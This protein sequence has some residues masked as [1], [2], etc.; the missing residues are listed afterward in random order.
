MQSTTL[1]DED[2][3]RFLSE[4]AALHFFQPMPLLLSD[5][6][7]RF[8][9]A[10][11]GAHWAYQELGE[12]AVIFCLHDATPQYNTLHTALSLG[13]IVW[14]VLEPLLAILRMWEHNGFSGKGNDSLANTFR[15]GIRPLV[16][17]YG[18]ETFWPANLVRLCEATLR[19][20]D[21]EVELD[22][23]VEVAV[24][25]PVRPRPDSGLGLSQDSPEVPTVSCSPAVRP[26]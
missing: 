23:E 25:S 3:L 16:A 6:L 22:M 13:S 12:S 7:Q 14:E 1:N 11:E 18:E 17:E 4:A 8:N 20:S 9:E 21:P 10:L 15:D 5:A 26:A 2:I 19:G 24:F